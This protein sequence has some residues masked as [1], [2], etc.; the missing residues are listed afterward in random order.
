MEAKDIND[1]ISIKKFIIHRRSLDGA[2]YDVTKARNFL[3]VVGI[4]DYEKWPK[5]NNAVR[6]ANDVT[7]V[8]MQRYGFEFDYVT[9]LKN[10]QATRANIYK[11]LRALIE[12]VTAQDNLVIYYSGHGYFDELLNEGYWIPVEASTGNTGEYLSNSDILKLVG[13]IDSQHT[14]LMADACFS[15]SLFAD[16]KRG[17][18]DNVERY[19]SRWGLASG[20]LEVVS[21]GEI[22]TNSPFA[23]AVLQFLKDNDKDKIAISESV[24]YV[25]VKVAETSNQTPLG[26]PLKVSGDE[27]GE[28]VLHQKK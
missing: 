20:R 10:E 11:S 2:E 27:G 13:N 16:S 12:R 9:I 6:D 18:T 7:H 19:K 22:G 25:K 4:N 1:N 3:F 5:L 21:D 26:N 8:L 28:L 17:F 23:T 14:F 24:Q 15:G